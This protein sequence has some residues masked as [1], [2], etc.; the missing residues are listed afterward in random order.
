M[1][2]YKV[3][4]KKSAQK[5]I[6]SIKNQ[7]IRDRI[8]SIL[9]GFETNPLP[10]GTKKI[11]GTKDSYRIRQGDYRVIYT[12]VKDELIVHVVKVA[13]RREVYRDF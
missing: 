4:I 10:T 9:V 7:E 6:R 5:E 13:H 8:V 11:K 2:S 3:I 1:A 12:I